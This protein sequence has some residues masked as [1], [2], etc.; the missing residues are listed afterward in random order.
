MYYVYIELDGSFTN[1]YTLM[2]INKIYNESAQS[3]SN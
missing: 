3:M 2:F 1:V